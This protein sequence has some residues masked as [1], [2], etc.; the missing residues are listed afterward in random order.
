MTEEVN[1]ELGQPFGLLFFNPLITQDKVLSQKTLSIQFPKRIEKRKKRRQP[2]TNLAAVR[3]NILY[4]TDL[5]SSHGA[6]ASTGSVSASSN[7]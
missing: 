2:T 3:L 7:N 4:Y 5:L 1:T 6:S